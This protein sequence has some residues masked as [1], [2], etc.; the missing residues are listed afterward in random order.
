MGDLSR[1]KAETI[2][3]FEKKCLAPGSLSEQCGAATCGI[4]LQFF[5]PAFQFQRFSSPLQR[6]FRNLPQ[7][8]QVFE[9][10]RNGNIPKVE[11]P[12]IIYHSSFIIHH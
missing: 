3:H 2:P 7:N 12:F 9:I 10:I 11:P 8:G 4:C 1:K 5:V 6:F